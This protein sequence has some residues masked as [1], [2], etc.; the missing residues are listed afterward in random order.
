MKRNI[1]ARV[2]RRLQSRYVCTA[3]VN[4]E[5]IDFYFCTKQHKFSHLDK[6]SYR[7]ADPG[8][9]RVHWAPEGKKIRACTFGK[10]R[11]RKR[12]ASSC[13]VRLFAGTAAYRGLGIFHSR[14]GKTKCTDQERAARG[15]IG[16]WLSHCFSPGRREL[17]TRKAR[18]PRRS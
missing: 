6:C 17:C 8:K 11:A 4:A 1:S 9:E 13:P 5:G 14:R 12:V 18:P 16:V 2:E 15:C 3:R 7:F 10:D